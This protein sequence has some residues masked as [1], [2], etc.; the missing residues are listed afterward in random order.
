MVIDGI[1]ERLSGGNIF[2]INVFGYFPQNLAVEVL[3]DHGLVEVVHVKIKLV[4]QQSA[5]GNFAGKRIINGHCIAVF[6]V[7]TLLTESRAELVRRVMVHQESVNDRLPVGVAEHG[8]SENLRGLERGRGRQSDF[9]RLKIVDDLAVFALV[10]ALIAVQLL[11]VGHFPVKN[12]APV[13]FIH[14]DQII[15]GDR[16]HGL[17]AFT[18]QNAFDHALHSGDVDTGFLVDCFIRQPVDGVNLVQGMQFLK[19]DVLEYIQSLRAQGIAIHKEQDATETF[20]FQKAVH[21]AQHCPGFPRPRGHGQQNRLRPALHGPL[22]RLDGAE[23]VLTQIE[24][25]FIGKKVGGHGFKASVALGNIA[26]QK[27][28][29]TG[30]TH[31]AVQGLGRIGSMAHVLKPDAGFFLVLP[32]IG[33]AVGGKEKG[34]A[35][36]AP[37][38]YGVSQVLLADM[39]GVVL[40]LMVEHSGNILVAGLGLND[41]HQPRTR[42]QSIVGK[43]P[44]AHRG[45]RGPFGY[46]Q[47]PS[48]LRSR[49]EGM[50]Q[51]FGIRL[52]AHFSELFVNEI[53]GFG[54]RHMALARGNGGAFAA[55]V[56]RHGSCLR[57]AGNSLIRQGVFLPGFLF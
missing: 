27:L 16:R 24:A 19:L 20:A 54:F 42:K 17:A 23:L 28:F 44:V 57:C 15:V 33:S 38:A 45:I 18:V 53:P 35:E 50:A 9:D 32:D 11:V 13:R 55:D 1:N 4:F 41:A 14:D 3:I 34:H 5:V 52:P 47:I 12:I 48:G 8:R 6:V 21:H 10:V 25:V 49:A 36:A 29:Q 37:L 31:P 7:N 2:G 26:L 51:G 22:G 30:G 39:A 46:G 40:T 56:F 43:T